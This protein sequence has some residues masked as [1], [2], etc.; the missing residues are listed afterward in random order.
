MLK[1]VIF[2]MDGVLVDSMSDHAE[3]VQHIFDE[4][5]VGWT[6][7][8]SLREKEREPLI[9][10]NSC[11]GKAPGIHQIMIYRILLRDILLSLTDS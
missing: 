3:A 6:N 2:D 7:R 10:W 11:F 9:S 8:T 4:M 5:G 1:A